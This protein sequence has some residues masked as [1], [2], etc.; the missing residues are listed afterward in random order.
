MVSFN[1]QSPAVVFSAF[2][3]APGPVSGHFTVTVTARLAPSTG[4]Y[5]VAKTDKS[6]Q[7]RPY[8]LYVSPTSNRLLVYYQPNNGAARASVRFNTPI[9]DGL[10]HRI[11]V[12]FGGANGTQVTFRLD[13][14]IAGTATLAAGVDDCPTPSEDC[15]LQVI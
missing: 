4:G 15:V 9:N 6:G 10:F 11:M 7:I 1:G 14:S 2:G 5:L 13:G 12:T 3:P 8:A